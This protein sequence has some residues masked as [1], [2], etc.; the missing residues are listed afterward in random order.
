MTTQDCYFSKIAFILNRAGGMYKILRGPALR[1]LNLL[2]I[3]VN[4]HNIVSGK[5]WV[6]GAITPMPLPQFRRPV[7]CI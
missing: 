1:D 3:L 2:K 5:I 6:C 7:Q 4:P